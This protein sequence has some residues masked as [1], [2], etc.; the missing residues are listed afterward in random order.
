MRCMAGALRAP[1][2]HPVTVTE[3]HDTDSAA[4]GQGT[5][6]CLGHCVH[7]ST[8]IV[9]GIIIIVLSFEY[10]GGKLICFLQI[11]IPLPEKELGRTPD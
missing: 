11:Y 10:F 6:A 1:S 9:L 7:L 4:R 3:I 5:W 2:R 8:A